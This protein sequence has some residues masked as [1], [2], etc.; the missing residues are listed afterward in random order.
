VIS[1]VISTTSA[2]QPATPHAATAALPVPVVSV[3][4]PRPLLRSR[5]SSPAW[6]ALANWESHPES[7]RDRVRPVLCSYFPTN[8]SKVYL[9][10]FQPSAKLLRQIE[11]RL[12]FWRGR[13]QIRVRRNFTVFGIHIFS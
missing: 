8:D 10:T 6:P 11:Q 13:Q 4:A 3:G 7:R 1:V 5:G 12:E 9:T 2:L